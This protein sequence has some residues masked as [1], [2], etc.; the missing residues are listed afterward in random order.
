V[1]V[2]RVFDALIQNTDRNIGN[3]IWSNDWKMWLIDHTRAFRLDP[4]LR[5]PDQ[6]SRC[7]RTL[8]ERLRALTPEILE[9]TVGSSL[10]RAEQEALLARR[11]KI[12]MHYEDRIARLG[13]VVV[14]FTL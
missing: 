10:T 7:D 13:E 14:L 1:H 9:K 3:S 11:D 4:N 6:L 2:Q 8:L 5:R 12:V